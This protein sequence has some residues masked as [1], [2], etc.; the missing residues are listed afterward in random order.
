MIPNIVS[1]I[2]FPV[3]AEH[4]KNGTLQLFIISFGILLGELVNR[5][6]LFCDEYSQKKKFKRSFK[7]VFIKK[8]KQFGTILILATVI[9]LFL[10]YLGHVNLD[11][12]ICSVVAFVWF[13]LRIFRLLNNVIEDMEMLED[14]HAMLGPGLAA[15]YWVSF[16]RWALKSDIRQKMEDY[17]RSVLQM[18]SKIQKDGTAI[19]ADYRSFDKFI[20]LLPD[21]CHL[22][23]RDE[24]ILKEENIFECIPELCLGASCSHKIEFELDAELKRKP[25]KQNVQWIYEKA[26]YEKEAT[27]PEMKEEKR[28]SKKIFVVFDFPQLLQSAMGPDRGWDEKDQPGARKKNIKSF[29]KTLNNLMNPSEFKQFEKNVMFLPFPNRKEPLKEPLSAVLRKRILEFEAECKERVYSSSSGAE[30][31]A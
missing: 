13:C 20:I 26:E 30:S 10:H 6:A 3:T 17:Q 28:N 29:K 18:S 19:V 12:K 4:L 25:M 14:T 7:F 31:E 15:N 8:H 11:L 21:D 22:K 27:T 24:R 5:L 1:D 16:L 9:S 23:I 2:K